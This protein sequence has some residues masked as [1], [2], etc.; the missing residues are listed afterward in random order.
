MNLGQL[1]ET[2]EQSYKL[3]VANLEEEL[4]KQRALLATLEEKHQKEQQL[5]L[6]AWQEAGLH[7]LRSHAQA[8][9]AQHPRAPPAR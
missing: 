2:A 4:D 6:Q 3:Q 9:G 1:S 7:S 8:N 5:M